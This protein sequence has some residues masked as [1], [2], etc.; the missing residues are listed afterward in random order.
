MKKEETEKVYE[1]KFD[2]FRDCAYLEQFGKI[3]EGYGLE[4]APIE[5]F[6]LYALDRVFTTPNGVNR[7]FG[8]EYFNEQEKFKAYRK[9]EDWKSKI[10]GHQE[11][12]FF[13]P[14]YIPKNAERRQVEQMVVG[15]EKYIGEHPEAMHA[16][17]IHGRY[18]QVLQKVA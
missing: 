18:M 16:R 4:K 12:S 15:L 11:E 1:P 2:I 9:L 5:R 7:E 10:S 14:D 17:E 13:G 8:N 6:R 3:L